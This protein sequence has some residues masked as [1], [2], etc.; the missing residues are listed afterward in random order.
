MAKKESNDA[1]ES[2]PKG[3]ALVL[4]IFLIL[5]VVLWASVYLILLSRG[6]TI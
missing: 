4:V 5:I 1:Q 3:A 2:H 6:V